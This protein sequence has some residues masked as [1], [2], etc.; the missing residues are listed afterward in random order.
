MPKRDQQMQ[1]TMH[2]HLVLERDG[3]NEDERS[4]PA[5]LSSESEVK[6]WFGR[7][8][9]SHEEG[10]IDLTRAQDGLPLLFNHD[11]NKPIGLVKEV[12]HADGKTRGILHFSENSL[13]EEIWNDVRGGFLKDISIGYRVSEWLENDDDDI[14]R[15][16]Q[17]E[18]LEASVVTVP[19]D[20]QVGINRSNE[21]N[22]MS[23][24]PQ[25]GENGKPEDGQR[26]AGF[27]STFKAGE[28]LGQQ[29]GI[30]AER[31]RVADIEATFARDAYSGDKFQALK[32]QCIQEGTSLEDTRSALLDL[33][34]GNKQPLAGGKDGQRAEHSISMGED[35]VQKFANAAENALSVRAGIEKDADKVRSAK[36]SGLQSLDLVGFAREYLR[37]IG[38]SVGGDRMDIVGSALSRS[39][40]TADFGMILANVAN[41]SIL[42]GYMEM[43]ETWRKWAAI[44]NLSD[45]KTSTRV[46]L[47][48]F[49]NLERVNEGG[50]YKYGEMSDNGETIKLGTYGK[51]FRITR[52]AII[53]DDLSML[54]TIPMR[55]GQAASRTVGDTAY[56]ALLSNPSLS[57]GKALFSADHKNLATGGAAAALSV[58]SL[59]KAKVTMAKQIAPGGKKASGTRGKTLLVPM[60]LETAANQLIAS[61]YDPSKPGAE[62]PNPFRS[63]YE[64]VSDVRLDDDSETAWYLMADAGM[65]D[66]IEVAFLNGNETPYMEQQSAFNRDTMD[67]K[68]RIDVAAAP[69]G[70]QGV[71][72]NNGA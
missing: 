33:V 9:L 42:K 23:K 3:I 24:K 17:W 52:E 28:K 63:V 47:S 2:R 26:S 57:D 67:Y 35:G 21:E 8:V 11:H 10:A 25:P 41:K 60:S 44:G 49:D 51:L 22:T 50:D 15:A 68:V 39:H 4:V 5:A 12:T 54:T 19:A 66:T 7:E 31:Q 64:V 65:H 56:S 53:N 14:V 40:S 58:A 6:R 1:E 32:T 69:M 29:A 37:S 62:V 20:T 55:M 70:Y 36:E 13:A 46:G 61:Q 43:E 71:Y 18:L 34:G 27:D 48:N 59:D 16:T 45:F 30:E 72:K 38:A